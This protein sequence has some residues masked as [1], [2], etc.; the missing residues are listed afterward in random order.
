MKILH[1][2]DEYDDPKEGSVPPIIFNTSRYIVEK[3]H[4]VTILVLEREKV[5]NFRFGPSMEYKTNVRF[6]RLKAKKFASKPYNEINKFPFGP[7]RLILDGI[8]SAITINKFLKKNNFDI[9]HVHFPFAA[10]ILAIL[11]RKLRKK[12]VYTAHADEYRLGLSSRL[13]LPLYFMFF[14]PDLY[15]MKRVRKTIVL[16]EILRRGLVFSGRIKPERIAVVRNGVDANKFNPN[17][18][19]GDV[20]MKYELDGKVSILF[21]GN[22]ILRKGIEYIVKAADILVNELD[23]DDTLFLIAGNLS[24]DE[25]Y[26]EKIKGLIKNYEL[27]GN[28]NLLGFLPYEE[29]KKLYVAC[30]IFI[31][32]SLEE[33][34]GVVLTEAIASGSPAIGTEVGGIPMQI[35]DGWNGFL[36]EP[37]NEKQLAEK[38]RY[39]ID[40]EEERIRMGKNSRKLAEEEFDWRKITE[41]YLKIYLE[42]IDNGR[43]K[44]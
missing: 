3:G 7:L 24:L 5:E 34:F 2:Y 15:L 13:K 42:V 26:V 43:N 1:I 17:M 18:N 11:N 6:V 21:T 40:N 29:L 36:V 37:A 20:R 31:L 32:P 33:G 10:N 41:E 16:N 35:K 22:I 9:I 4:D 30:D 28:V 27:E 23:Y 19:V 38:I 25:D 12:M 8:T 44:L 39:L 14:S